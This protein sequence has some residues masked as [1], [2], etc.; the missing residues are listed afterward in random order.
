[1][2]SVLDDERESVLDEALSFPTTL[3]GL[4]AG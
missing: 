2:V 1:M 4:P 3:R